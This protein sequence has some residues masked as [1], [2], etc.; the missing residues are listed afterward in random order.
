ML[1]LEFISRIL[2]CNSYVCR[3]GFRLFAAVWQRTLKKLRTLKFFGTKST[4]FE[5]IF[6]SALNLGPCSHL[7]DGVSKC[8]NSLLN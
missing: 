7:I 3:H 2:I 8:Y 1:N 6:Q 5:K 4:H